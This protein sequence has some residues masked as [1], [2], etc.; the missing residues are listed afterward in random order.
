MASLIE[1]EG[2]NFSLPKPIL[3][4]LVRVLEQHYSDDEHLS[5]TMGVDVKKMIFYDILQILQ[6]CKDD[7]MKINK[8]NLKLKMKTKKYKN[9]SLGEALALLICLYG[10][11]PL[12]VNDYLIKVPVLIYIPNQSSYKLSKS[13][14]VVIDL[15]ELL[16]ENIKNDLLK[17]WIKDILKFNDHFIETSSWME[18]SIQERNLIALVDIAVKFLQASM[19]QF[20]KA[21]FSKYERDDP[22]IAKIA[23]NIK[24]NASYNHE[25]VHDMM[26]EIN[27][28]DNME[29]EK[30]LG[31]D[32]K[33]QK[34]EML[35]TLQKKVNSIY[36][37]AIPKIN[38]QNIKRK[39]GLQEIINFY[40]NILRVHENKEVSE[41]LY[42]QVTREID[43]DQFHTIKSFSSSKKNLKTRNL[44]EV[45]DLENILYS[46]QY[47]RWMLD[48][49]S[50]VHSIDEL[51]ELLTKT[52]LEQKKK[53]QD[54]KAE[55]LLDMGSIE[56]KKNLSAALMKE[57][58]ALEQHASSQF[59]LKY[60]LRRFEE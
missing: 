18:R 33:N 30:R 42:E 4:W 44:N 12:I 40:A 14:Y 49:K 45:V 59:D 46:S 51:I 17:E 58:D 57:I 41:D 13:P 3:E 32:L 47:E 48:L 60:N 7:T 5:L 29:L 16:K 9:R 22:K 27:I 38:A 31:D 19:L 56:E 52:F 11:L 24:Y 50:K 1:S 36:N 35:K 20:E 8:Y 10:Y 23:K 39:K 21:Y 34:Q 53:I 25:E 26:S 54:E 6:Y 2:R 37:T 55:D 43:F 28:L 15:E